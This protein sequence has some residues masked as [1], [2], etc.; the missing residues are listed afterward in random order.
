MV[1]SAPSLI[2]M[3]PDAIALSR[4]LAGRSP[5]EREAY[6]RQHQVDPVLRA[7]I[8]SLLP[9]NAP[10]AVTV[11]IIGRRLGVFE[12]EELLGVGGMG[13]VYRARDT[14]LGRD[15]ALKIIRRAL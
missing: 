13:E 12:V 10:A 4:E 8:E 6:Y 7:E 14:R 11:P 2:T 9:V 1:T 3:N 5:S 15:V